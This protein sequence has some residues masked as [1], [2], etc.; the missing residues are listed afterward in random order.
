MVNIPQR[1]ELLE[2]VARL[3]P[4]VSRVLGESFDHRRPTVPSRLLQDFLFERDMER[5][6]TLV[7]MEHGNHTQRE[8][9]TVFDEFAVPMNSPSAKRWFPFGLVGTDRR[10]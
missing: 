5:P 2:Q 4:Q 7:W 9:R 1:P 10:G 3:E 6:G 8:L